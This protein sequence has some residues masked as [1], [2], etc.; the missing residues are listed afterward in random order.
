M[1]KLNT[2]RPKAAEPATDILERGI[3]STVYWLCNEDDSGK[4]IFRMQFYGSEYVV[5]VCP[6]CGRELKLDF[7]EFCRVMHDGDLFSTMVLCQDCAKIRQN[8][9]D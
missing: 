7:Y 3:L 1:C 5:T 4:E 9:N 8:S 6:E 2:N